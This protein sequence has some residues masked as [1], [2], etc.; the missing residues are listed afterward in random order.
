M[1]ERVL[2]PVSHSHTFTFC[3]SF[4]V[5]NL[6]SKF[7]V[8]LFSRDIQLL[9]FPVSVGAQTS[10]RR[11]RNQ[12]KLPVKIKKGMNES[13]REGEGVEVGAIWCKAQTPAMITPEE[14]TNNNNNPFLVHFFIYEQKKL[15]LNF[16]DVKNF[17]PQE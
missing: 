13:V 5:A 1:T 11:P 8:R 9:L 3:L 15:N 14:Q 17:F 7:V 10:F 6:Y 12:R 16:G 2:K 4:F